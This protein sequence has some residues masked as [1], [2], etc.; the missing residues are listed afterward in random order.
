MQSRTAALTM[1]LVGAMTSLAW[2][3]P[4]LTAQDPPFTMR[5]GA[6][7]QVRG[8][9]ADPANAD[10]TTTVRIRRGRLSASGAAYEHFNYA[11]QLELPGSGA[12]LI[13]ANIR[14]SL[15]PLVTIWFGQGKAYFGRQQLNSSGNLNFVDRTIV[16][17]RFSAGRQ[18]G[19]AVLGSPLDGQLEYNLGIYNGNGINQ[20]SNPNNRFMS[21]ARVV[22]TPLGS[23]SPAESAHDYP[24]TPRMALG[25]S[26][27]N[28]TVTGATGDTEITRL[29]AEAA[30]KLRGI[31]MT[32]EFYREW[33]EPPAGEEDYTTNG[34]YTQFGYLL[35]NR[36]HEVAARLAT[37]Q[38]ASSGSSGDLVETGV[39]FSHYFQAHRAKIQMDLRNIRDRDSGTDDRE[40]RVQFQLTI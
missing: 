2:A 29:N 28:N 12:R 14:A 17:G 27:L 10:E 5:I 21:V 23:Y 11:L 34:W 9:Y 16:D 3:E 37:I 25:I 1:V 7:T 18:Q 6:R 40:I 15:S 19:I 35:S 38:A 36:K 24:E 32:G 39:A 33:A 26:A 13:D 30:F 20:S 31:N 4:V 22:A 8:T